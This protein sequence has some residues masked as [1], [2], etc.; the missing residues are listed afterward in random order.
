MIKFIAD[1]MLGGLARYLRMMGIY[2]EYYNNIKDKDLIKLL[3]EDESKVL[4]TKDRILK[5]ETPKYSE[6]IFIIKSDDKI[7]QAKEVINNFNLKNHIKPFS[8]CLEC[9]T[10]IRKIPKKE[11]KNLVPEETYKSIK[12]FFI[13]PEC[14]KVYWFSTHTERMDIIIQRILNSNH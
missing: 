7:E 13:C 12:E 2:T 4:L 5:N 8:R 6:R 11:V 14:K 3:E 10:E 9:N 1:S